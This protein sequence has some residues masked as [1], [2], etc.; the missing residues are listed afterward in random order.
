MAVESDG[1]L[2]TALTSFAE[3]A[4]DCL[5]VVIS[6]VHSH[7]VADPGGGKGGA[8]APPYMAASNVFLRT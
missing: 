7:V 8:N 5:H 4:A 2:R 1:D 3:V 6:T